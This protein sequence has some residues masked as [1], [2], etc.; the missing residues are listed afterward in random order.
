MYHFMKVYVSL[1]SVNKK[2]ISKNF[3]GR[4]GVRE[5]FFIRTDVCEE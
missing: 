1:T 4:N 2:I 5:E 3:L